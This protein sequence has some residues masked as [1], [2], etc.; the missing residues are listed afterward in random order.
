MEIEKANPARL[1]GHL[2]RAPVRNPMKSLTAR[3]LVFFLVAASS[4]LGV[5]SQTGSALENESTPNEREAV[6]KDLLE[7]FEL[8]KFERYSETVAFFVYRGPEEN[9]KWID[10]YDFKDPEERRE[11]EAIAGEIKR[12]LW[13]SDSYEFSEFVEKVQSKR[14]WYIWRLTFRSGDKQA[15]ITFAFLKIKGRYAIGDIDGQSA[16]L[17]LLSETV[18]QGTV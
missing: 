18:N 11:V 14:R 2:R 17:R 3:I 13:Q 16:Y 6:K 8:C 7:L 9:R 4:A 15:T 5:R 10:V 12:L 1:V